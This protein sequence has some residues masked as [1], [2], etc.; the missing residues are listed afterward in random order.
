MLLKVPSN[1]SLFDVEHG[2]RGG[3]ELNWVEK[4]KNYGWPVISYGINYDGT[5]MTELTHKEGMEQPVTYW[6][7]SLAV[8]GLNFYSGN[9][10]PNWKNNLFLASLAAQELRRIEIKGGQVVTQEVLFKNLGRIRHVVGGPDGALYVL[11]PER[12]AR[13]APAK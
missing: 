10:F 11:L 13:L 8:C 4:G 1:G 2:P 12:I 7:P 9:L 3:D 5:T 6:T